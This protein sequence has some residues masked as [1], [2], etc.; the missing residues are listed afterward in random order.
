MKKHRAAAALAAVLAL[1]AC[2]LAGPNPATL[3]AD[4]SGRTLRLIAGEELLVALPGNPSTGYGWTAEYAPA[5]LEQ[6]GREEFSRNDA[7]DRMV[8]VGGVFT[9]RFRARAGGS[10]VVRFFYARPWEKGIPPARTVEY[11]VVVE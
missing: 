2:A 6:I 5:L 9:W 3:T 8:G 11:R 4:D 1:S 10:G 7:P